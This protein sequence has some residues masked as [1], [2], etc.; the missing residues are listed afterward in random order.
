MFLTEYKAIVSDFDGTLAD[1]KWQ[2]T[3]KVQTSIRE[4]INSGR[5]FSIATGKQ[6][7]HIKSV[8]K[9]LGLTTPQIVR[10]GS[11]VVDGQTGAVIYAEYINQPTL[12]KV[13]ELLT[14]SPIPFTAESDNIL[15]T[16]DGNPL[17]E[18]P[19]VKYKKIT[20]MANDK[21]FKIVLWTESLDEEYVENYIHKNIMGKFNTIE[22]VK[23]YTP[24]LKSWQI[25]S[26]KGTK[27]FAVRKLAELLKISTDKVIGI[28]DS[29]NDV[30]LLLACGYKVAMDNGPAELKKISDLIVPSYLDNGV[31]ALINKINISYLC[32]R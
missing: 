24:S 18:V 4:W 1:E 27:Y 15:Y 29:Y 10:G 14:Q 7:R 26:S 17:P 11:E 16:F 20:E 32:P 3:E 28:G 9:L 25:T 12:N 19:G 30:P 5:H 22:T 31:S 2:V 8:C 21:I 13:I 6:Y 23:S